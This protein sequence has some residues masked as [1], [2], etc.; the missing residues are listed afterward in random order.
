MYPFDMLKR[1]LVATANEFV[2]QIGTHHWQPIAGVYELRVW[3]PFTEKVGEPHDWVP[4]A[5]NPFIPK[6]EKRVATTAWGYSGDE[7]PVDLGCVFFIKGLFT[8][9]AKYGHVDEKRGLIVV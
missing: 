9:A 7:L 8:R 1:P 4:E 6:H 3:G 2:R 5:D